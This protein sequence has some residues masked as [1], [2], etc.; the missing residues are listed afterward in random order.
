MRAIVPGAAAGGPGQR[1]QVIRQARGPQA[2][3]MLALAAAAAA[4]DGVAP[5][6][7]QTQLQ[8][9]YPADEPSRCL[10]LW[11]DGDLGGFAFLG[12]ADPVAG[13]TGEL[14]VHPRH[15]RQ[16]LGTVLAR[17]AAESERLPVRLWA[18]GDLP[19]AA[20][21]ARV[22][23]YH[24]VRELWRMHR[25]LREV[26]DPPRL[27]NG[28][29]LRAFVPGQDEDKW[30]TVN[31]RAFADHP[32]QGKWTSQDLDRREREPWFDPA[33]FFLAEQDGRL[34]GFHWTKLHRL[35]RPVGGDGGTGRAGPGVKYQ[36]PAG[37]IY[38]L[39]VDPRQQGTGLGRALAVAGLR[40]LKDQGA[41][42]AFLYVEA[43]HVAAVRLY[44]SLGFAYAASDVMYEH[45]PA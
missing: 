40:Y 1:L 7:E 45:R 43:A 30:L 13:R 18:H 15:R 20:G 22:A 19:A 38:V 6:S 26:I 17:A 16:G 5:L 4:A 29:R 41:A 8:L 35:P 12:P 39:G 9:R 24:R 34:V 27:P 36:E 3:A 2:E 11:R 25:S 31:R 32:E 14:V 37:E 28:I 10:L 44:E 42:S 23:G 21:L 33:G